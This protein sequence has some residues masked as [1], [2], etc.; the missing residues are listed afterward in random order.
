MIFNQV[1]GLLAKEEVEYGVAETLDNDEDGCLPFFGDGDLPAPEPVQYEFDGN[2]GRAAATLAPQKRTSPNG[3]SRQ[4]QFKVLPRGRGSAYSSS[5]TPPNEVHR[6]LKAAGFVATY[7]A[8]PTPQW[9]YTPQPAGDGYTSLT[10]KWFAQNRLWLNKG[11]LADLSINGE[12]LGMPVWSFDSRGIADLPSDLSLPVVTYSAADIVPPVN[13][14]I[15]VVIGDY[16]SATLRSHSLK[17]SRKMG[18]PRLA[19]NLA[20]GHAGF[21]PGGVM[22][23]LTLV[24]EQTA[25]PGDPFHDVAG[26]NP[27]ALREAATRIPV[28]LQYPGAQYFRHKYGMANAQVIDVRNTADENVALWEIDFMGTPSTPSADDVDYILFN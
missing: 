3:R 24:I 23:V 17:R 7:S 14:G 12:G 15:S 9:L 5:N 2:T 19:Q 20:G 16:G 18:K 8:T 10:A 4:F 6:W 1:A 13:A 21:V 22:P 27:Y 25:D 28:S 11:V 26:L